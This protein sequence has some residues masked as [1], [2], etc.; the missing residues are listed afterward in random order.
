M[1]I[2]V[3]IDLGYEFDVKAKAAEVFELL[4]DVPAS[5]SHFP[6]VEKL[7]DLGDGVYQWEMEKVG[8]T[9]VNI[10]T[11]YASKYVSDK[12]KGTVKWTPVKGVGNALVGGHWKIVDNKKSTGLT[13][14]IQGE[15]EV[16]LPGLMK[17]I[18][19]PVVQGE[20]EKLVEKYIDN[21]IQRFGGEA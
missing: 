10:Q 3:K 14:A 20:F 2:T 6:K 13:L 19:V 5:V 1:S 7:T 8:T 9:Q 16:P 15:I 17:M 21:L 18:V 11:V 12:T 4:S